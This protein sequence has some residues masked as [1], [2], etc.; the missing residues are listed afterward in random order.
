MDIKITQNV[1][2]LKSRLI[3]SGLSNILVARHH[4]HHHTTRD[5]DVSYL[6]FLTRADDDL[7]TRGQSI[8]A[9]GIN[10]KDAQHACRISLFQE[11][12]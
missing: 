1:C 2:E 6:F 5:E 12:A 9:A 8:W 4:E 11:F 10:N 3:F 7:K